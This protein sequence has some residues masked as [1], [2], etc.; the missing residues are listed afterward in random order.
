MRICQIIHS[1]SFHQLIENFNNVLFYRYG[2]IFPKTNAGRLLT[3]TTLSVIIIWLP[4]QVAIIIDKQSHLTVYKRSKYSPKSGIDHV[5]IMGDVTSTD[6]RELFRELF[7]SDHEVCNINVVLLQ[8]NLPSDEVHEILQDSETSF[9][10]TYLKGNPLDANSHRRACL[11]SAA[12]VFFFADKFSQ[13]P[14]ETDSNNILLY[15]SVFNYMKRLKIPPPFVSLQLLKPENRILMAKE[16]SDS[17]T[18]CIVSVNEIRSAIIITS[19]MCPGTCAL[20]YNLVTSFKDHDLNTI[21]E[22]EAAEEEPD[23]F[24]DERVIDTWDEEYS[25]GACWEIYET[26]LSTAFEGFTFCD[27]ARFVYNE[28]GVLVFALR[29]DDLMTVEPAE[30]MLNPSDYILPRRDATKVEAYVLAKNASSSDLDTIH[31]KYRIQEVFT[32]TSS[33]SDRQGGV[34][35]ERAA[36]NR[37]RWNSIFKVELDVHAEDVT[38]PD[39]MEKQLEQLG[40]AENAFELDEKCF[41]QD[42]YCRHT[43]VSSDE[44]TIKRSLAVDFPLIRRHII[45][46]VRDLAVLP[47]LLLSFRFR[48]QSSGVKPNA[49]VVVTREE[50]SPALW[51]V[52]SILDELYFLKGNPKDQTTLRQAGIF[53]ASMV[54]ILADPPVDMNG[55]HQGGENDRSGSGRSLID[56]ESIFVYNLVSKLNPYVRILAELNDHDNIQFLDGGDDASYR[57]TPLY[58]SGAVLLTSIVDSLVVQSFYNPHIVGVVNKI[59]N[60]RTSH[61]AHKYNSSTIKSKCPKG[62]ST[63]YQVDIPLAYIDTSSNTVICNY[64]TLVE[65]F[66]ERGVLLMGI[67][68]NIPEKIA[69]GQMMNAKPYVYMNPQSCTRLFPCDKLYVLS[70][71][72]VESTTDTVRYRRMRTNVRRL[73]PFPYCLQSSV[74]T[75]RYFNLHRIFWSRYW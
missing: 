39:L 71:D 8:E 12:A 30:I 49:I 63:F 29:I 19:C 17:P 45:L 6:L 59:L 9:M 70:Q 3:M 64:G 52:I 53:K 73:I 10:V 25:E 11:D 74:L 4:E 72:N 47:T 54:V 24:D 16:P 28:Y 33:K 38:Q 34:S 57:L 32:I 58:A 26:R 18:E 21:M 46:I 7:H 55:R 65:D 35:M 62:G 5:I 13:S 48:R 69:V 61:F 56:A 23:V 22:S 41:V 42:Y 40:D 31:V 68:R 36:N 15:T 14:H 66:S 43:P 44:V 1:V 20:L 27:I 60:I 37:R 50:I 67:F 75:C 51:S 2:D